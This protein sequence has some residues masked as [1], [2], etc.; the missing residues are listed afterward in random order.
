MRH[1]SIARCESVGPDGR[2]IF[3]YLGQWRHR[4][5]TR[6][7]T[8]LTGVSTIAC[9]R[10]SGSQSICSSYSHHISSYLLLSS[11]LHQKWSPKRLRKQ[12]SSPIQNVG[13]A[14]C[15]A[16]WHSLTVISGVLGAFSQIQKDH[17]KH[18]VHMATLKT[19]G[20]LNASLFSPRRHL[21]TRH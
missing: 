10:P 13:H 5:A 1:I 2:R 3:P 11:K 4:R 20:M 12:R 9:P 7:L 21:L 14:R 8:W 16:V 17:R 15:F 18:A 6:D 19:Q